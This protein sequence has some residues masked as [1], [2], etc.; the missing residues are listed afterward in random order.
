VKKPTNASDGKG[1]QQVLSVYISD[2]ETR[3]EW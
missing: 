3:M 1:L 2:N